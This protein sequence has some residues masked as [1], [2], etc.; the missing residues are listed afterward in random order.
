MMVDESR[1]VRRFNTIDGMILVAALALW[2]SIMPGY[3]V[4]VPRALRDLCRVAYDLAG[5]TTWTMPGPRWMGWMDLHVA[6]HNLLAPWP[7]LLGYLV[8]AVL[9]LALRQ[10][11]PS[12]RHFVRQSGVGGC[13][14]LATYAVVRL[15]IWWIGGERIPFA[16]DA[17]F[18]GLLLWVVLGR[19]PWRAE[20]TWLDRLGRGVAGYW[21]LALMARAADHVLL[22]CTV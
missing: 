21:M 10:P 13:L 3:F 5:A 7:F 6:I 4:T 1:L 17:V 9:I 19:R 15:E 2:L 22:G 16:A 18:A 14:L 8:P 11:R 12:W 20:P